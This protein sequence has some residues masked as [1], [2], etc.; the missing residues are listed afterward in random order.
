MVD[1][2]RVFKVF[3]QRPTNIMRPSAKK[4]NYF[5][6]HCQWKITY[7][8]ATRKFLKACYVARK[9]NYPLYKL[10]Y[11]LERESVHIWICLDFNKYQYSFRYPFDELVS[12]ESPANI[13]A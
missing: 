13:I 12:I 6:S 11:R 1:K 2:S 5:Q 3:S 10:S 9:Q 8:T 4:N 7:A